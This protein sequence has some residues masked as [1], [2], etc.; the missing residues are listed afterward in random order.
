[1]TKISK[2][3]VDTMNDTLGLVQWPEEN[4]NGDRGTGMRFS[5]H[6]LIYTVNLPHVWMERGVG[7]FVLV[8]LLHSDIRPLP[9]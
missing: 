9:L 7:G 6:V 2:F 1:M 5:L 3:R 8:E 4:L